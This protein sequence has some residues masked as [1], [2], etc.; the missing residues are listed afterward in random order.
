MMWKLAEII[1]N[2]EKRVS[3]LEAE[4]DRQEQYSR[5]TNLRI[6]GLAE[7]QEGTTDDNVCL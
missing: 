1:D 5:R 2:F 3:E 6:Q 7:S 4:Q